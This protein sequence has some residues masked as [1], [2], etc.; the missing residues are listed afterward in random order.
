MLSTV[1]SPFKNT[2]IFNFY[3]NAINRKLSLGK[4]NSCLYIVI[5]LISGEM[6]LHPCLNAKLL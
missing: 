1:I 3:N 6:D 5:Q 2:I 4:V